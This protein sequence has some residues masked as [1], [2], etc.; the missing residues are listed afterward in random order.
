MIIRLNIFNILVQTVNIFPQPRGCIPNHNNQNI[1]LIPD[2]PLKCTQ[3]TKQ[4]CLF[5]GVDSY[6]DEQNEYSPASQQDTGPGQSPHSRVATPD[7]ELITYTRQIDD[8]ENCYS[9]GLIRTEG[10]MHNFMPDEVMPKFCVGIF[11]LF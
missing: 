4:T 7:G 10:Y 3:P 6:G 9:S 11:S 8:E 1:L 2:M 5:A